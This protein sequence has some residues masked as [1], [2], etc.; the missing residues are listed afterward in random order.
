[1]SCESQHETCT[2]HNSRILFYCCSRTYNH[3][4][5]FLILGYLPKRYSLAFDFKGTL[6]VSQIY[7]GMA[8][9]S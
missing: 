1:M 7:S 2:S 4:Q 5:T 6:V 8:S 9:L 3:I